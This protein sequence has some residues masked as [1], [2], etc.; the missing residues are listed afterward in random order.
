M[1]PYRQ[2]DAYLFPHW[3]CKPS[4]E[5]T[6]TK[7]PLKGEKGPRYKLL[8]LSG[9]PPAWVPGPCVC[10][11]LGP[12][13]HCLITSCSGRRV[14]GFPGPG[15]PQ[16]VCSWAQGEAAI[17]PG[18][19]PGSPGPCALPGDTRHTDR[20]ITLAGSA[21]A[22]S[23]AGGPAEERGRRAC[24]GS[25]HCTGWNGAWAPNMSPPGAAGS[26]DEVQV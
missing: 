2:G 13:T 11:L 12:R 6:F 18:R 4:E 10:V 7:Q 1:C 20:E 16:A 25:G 17:C 24:C 15:A 26:G 19:T 5:E 8:P 14:G 9:S 23:R 3:K 21:R 22:E